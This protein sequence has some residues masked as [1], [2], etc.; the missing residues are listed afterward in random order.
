MLKKDVPRFLI[1]FW[2][3]PDLGELW[4]HFENERHL[5]TYFGK[6]TMVL[7]AFLMNLHFIAK[8]I[9]F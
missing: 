3:F 4:D 6:K 9:V 1:I 7:E 8:T 5:E 2:Y